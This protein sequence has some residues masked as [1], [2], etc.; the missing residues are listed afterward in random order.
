[1]SLKVPSVYIW[2][3]TDRYTKV[4]EGSGLCVQ[5]GGCLVGYH[6]K[7]NDDDIANNNVF[8]V[9][10]CEIVMN[11]THTPSITEWRASL[12][13]LSTPRKDKL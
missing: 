4:D 13:L 5:G 6:H 8:V 3:V 7:L 1:M 10:I 2:R 12:K 11:V 9:W